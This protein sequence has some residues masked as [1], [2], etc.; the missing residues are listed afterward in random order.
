M[1]FL[2]ILSQ[3]SIMLFVN[4]MCVCL[5]AW[6]EILLNINIYLRALSIYIE[7]YMC[8]YQKKRLLQLE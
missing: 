1:K 2:S 3:A 8:D 5:C 4:C 7:I 6:P